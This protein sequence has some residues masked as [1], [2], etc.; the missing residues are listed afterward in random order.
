MN[1]QRHH[2][3]SLATLLF[4]IFLVNIFV[5][6]NVV[7]SSR[8][9]PFT[10][11][12]NSANDERVILTTYGFPFMIGGQMTGSDS[13]LYYYEAEYHDL[14]PV[15]RNGVVDFQRSLFGLVLN[16]LIGSVVILSIAIFIEKY[17]Y[18]KKLSPLSPNL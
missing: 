16:V 1:N 4:T 7:E 18:K 17:L 15:L 14:D 10:D 5:V 2:Q 6:L 3:I 11:F 9:L 12:N 8:K 13:A